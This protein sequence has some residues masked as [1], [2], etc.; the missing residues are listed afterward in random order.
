MKAKFLY[1]LYL[2]LFL[3]TETIMAQPVTL[4]EPRL[5]LET[6]QKMVADLAY[7]ETISVWL[8]EVSTPDADAVRAY[9]TV[10]EFTVAYKYGRSYKSDF[11]ATE[12]WQAEARFTLTSDGKYE[13]SERLTMNY[14]A[15]RLLD[16]SWHTD[17][18]EYIGGKPQAPPF[19]PA[20][21]TDDWKSYA[22]RAFNTL[23]WHLQKEDGDPA[24]ELIDEWDF[25]TGN[26]TEAP[27]ILFF[28]AQQVDKDGQ[29]YYEMEPGSLEW[30]NMKYNLFS[31]TKSGS[32]NA[33]FNPEPWRGGRHIPDRHELVINPDGTSRYTYT[34]YQLQPNDAIKTITAANLSGHWT[35]EDGLL[36]LYLEP[37]EPLV[38]KKITLRYCIDHNKLTL[39][40]HGYEELEYPR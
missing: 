21:D 4:S 29:I 5:V 38:I 6:T 15:T 7:G 17:D 33:P 9:G 16:G 26:A 24:A 20:G 34:I 31:R 8:I 3:I 2:L 11:G 36:V 1:G 30:Q 18:V 19:L 10:K 14:S 40:T 25:S 37:Q 23:R 13:I 32:A 12:E 28:G 35:V 22:V 27:W 39:T